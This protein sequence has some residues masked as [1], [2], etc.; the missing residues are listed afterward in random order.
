[1]KKQG[2]RLS[3][4]VWLAAS[5]TLAGPASAIPWPYTP[6]DQTHGLGNNYDEF[7]YYGSGG[8][9][10]H[11]GIDL[12]TPNTTTRTYSVSTGTITHETVNDPYYSGIMIGEPVAGGIGWLYWH[13][14]STTWQYDVGDPVA[15]NAYIGTTAYWSPA[16]FCHTHFNKV[17]GTGGYPWNWYI[18]TDNP[19]TYLE[20]NTDPNAPVFETTYQ[21]AKFAFRRNQAT[22]VLD[23]T[24]LSGDVDIISRI[25]DIVGMSQWKLNPWRIDYR[26]DG[27]T[28]SVPLANFVNFSGLKPDDTT[29]GVVYST[30]S[31]FTTQGD[32]NSRIYY[33]IV[34]NTDGDGVIESTDANQSWQTGNYRPGDY[35]VYVRAGDVGGNSVTDSMM[36]TIAGAVNVHVS[37]PEASHDFGGIPVGQTGTWS[38]HIQNTG[39]DWLSIRDITPSLVVFHAAPRHLYIPPSGDVAVNVTFTPAA[40]QVYLATLTISTNDP[41]AL[42]VVVNLQGRGLDVAG[43]GDDA[44]AGAAAFGIAGVRP[45]SQGGVEV[46][47]GL[48]RAGAAAIGVFDVTGRVIRT[49]AMRDAHAGVQTWTW[50]GRDDSGTRV[51]SGMYFVRLRA[52]ARTASAPCIIVR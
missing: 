6:F 33:F 19:L 23:P 45:M 37:L 4:L 2:I 40:V 5:A 34:T 49:A 43:V 15:V 50:N 7:Q 38:M 21:G 35:W 28:Q 46:L 52:G 44:S 51:A 27:A 31:P 18:A 14:T 47:Y 42:Q 25:Y 1:M 24:A 30:Q 41:A 29:I 48:D 26:I 9:Y 8:R 20:P 17:Q 10:Y 11:D 16:T 32:Y 3:L 13:I 12:V 39:A 36:C 22:T